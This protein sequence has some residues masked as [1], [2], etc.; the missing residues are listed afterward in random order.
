[1]NAA[2]CWQGKSSELQLHLQILFMVTVLLIFIFN[3]SG[4]WLCGSN[5]PTNKSDIE[6]QSQ[7]ILRF[8]AFVV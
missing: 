5:C 8:S 3:V 4:K 6:T 7:Q 2:G 1:M